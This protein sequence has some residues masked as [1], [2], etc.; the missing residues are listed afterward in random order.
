MRGPTRILLQLHLSYQRDSSALEINH[1]KIM[2]EKNPHMLAIDCYRFRVFTLNK[3]NGR[4]SI[5]NTLKTH[6]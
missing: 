5:C 1:E 4:L 6:S 2:E 3:T